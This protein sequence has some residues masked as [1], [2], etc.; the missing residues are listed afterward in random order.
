MSHFGSSHTLLVIITGTSRKC[1]FDKEEGEEYQPWNTSFND[2]FNPSTKP[3]SLTFNI[4]FVIPDITYNH[5]LS[6]GKCSS[7]LTSVCLL[8]VLTSF[9]QRK[10]IVGDIIQEYMLSDIETHLFLNCYFSQ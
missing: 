3:R 1:L 5:P 2:F 8:S 7:S 10:S 6:C 9:D 4:P